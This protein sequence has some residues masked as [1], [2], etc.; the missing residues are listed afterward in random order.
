MV[1]ES[2]GAGGLSQRICV[3]WR[4]DAP[5]K[6]LPLDGSRHI[7]RIFAWTIGPDN[8]LLLSSSFPLSCYTATQQLYDDRLDGCAYLPGISG[9]MADIGTETGETIE[10]RGD[11][12]DE[13]TTDT[14]R[15]TTRNGGPRCL[16]CTA[17]NVRRVANR[18]VIHRSE[19]KRCEI[20]LCKYFCCRI[21][22]YIIGFVME[23]F[24]SFLICV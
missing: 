21:N 24:I 18:S 7:K 16:L 4:R 2:W 19:T 8:E 17:A 9:E 3:L 6:H 5:N 22:A 15:H 10:R 12:T 23:K 1:S 14:H 11:G 20:R 13:T